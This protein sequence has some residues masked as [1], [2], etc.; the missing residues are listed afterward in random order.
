M[1]L[2]IHTHVDSQEG[3]STTGPQSARLT[4]QEGPSTT[5]PRV[6]PPACQHHIY[7]FLLCTVQG[8]RSNAA[9]ADAQLRRLKEE[10]SATDI[11]I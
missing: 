3:P 5:R 7:T 1:F 6:N 4:R 9:A 8:A 2:Y 11:D 10:S